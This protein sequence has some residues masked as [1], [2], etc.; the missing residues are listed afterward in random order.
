[1]P[2]NLK[3]LERYWQKLIGQGRSWLCSPESRMPRERDTQ[4][5]TL[6]SRML[7]RAWA[8]KGPLNWVTGNPGWRNKNK[9]G[10]D[11]GYPSLPMQPSRYCFQHCFSRNP[12]KHAWEMSSRKNVQAVRTQNKQ[13]ADMSSKRA[14]GAEARWWVLE[15]QVQTASL[16]KNGDY[17]VWW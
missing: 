17:H 10:M 2:S 5:G 4:E 14:A 13:R 16:L 8:G 11:R 15:S 12:Q 9:S 6:P 1:M 7:L 3:S